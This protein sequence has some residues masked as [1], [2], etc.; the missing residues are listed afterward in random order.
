MFASKSKF[1]A[2]YSIFSILAL[3]FYPLAQVQAK[4]INL[5]ASST[6]IVLIP[7]TV[8][9]SLLSGSGNRCLYVD[10]TGNLLAKGFDCGSASGGDNMGDHSATQNIRLNSY[11]LSGDAGNEGIFV[12]SAG[13]VGVGTNSITAGLRL[14]VSGNL[15]SSGTVSFSGPVYAGGGNRMITVD[16]A[17]VLGAAAIPVD[18]DIYWTGTAT[19]LVPATARTSLGLGAL[20]TLNAVTNTQITDVAW[21]KITG[22]PAACSAG[23]YVRAVGGTLTCST[24]S[25]GGSGT[26]DWVTKWTSSNTLVDSEI[27]SAPSGSGGGVGIGTSNVQPYKLNVAG[28]VNVGGRLTVSLETILNNLAGGGPRMVMVDND[29]LLSASS[30]PAS[31]VPAS[32]PT[33]HTLR[34]NGSNWVSD[35]NIF[36]NGTNVGIGTSVPGAYTL[37]VV[38]TSSFAGNFTTTGT[39]S[40][41]GPVYAGGGNRM[42][43][44]DN[45][46]VLGAAAIPAD[47]D[48]YW[49][50]TATNL[51]PAT[52]RTSLG[53]GALATLNAVTN[54]QITDVAWSKITGFPA[55]CSAGQYVTAVGGTLTCSTPA[56]GADIYWTGTATNLVPATARTSLGLGALATL[57]A[58]TNTQITDVAWSKITGFPAACSAGQ[59]V[60]AVGGT[61]TC[62]TPAGG[63]SGSGTT[64]YVSK[65]TAGSALGNSIIYDNGTYVGI[66]TSVP[67]TYKL[68]VAG[69]SN[70]GGNLTTTGTVSLTGPVYAGGGNRMIT[71]D[72]A[73]VLGAAAIPTD[74]DIY[75]TGT[76]T[77]LVP[78][79]ARTSLGLGALATLGAVSGGTG[80]TITDA[81]VTDADVSS[82][83]AITATKI[84]YGDLFITSAGTSGQIWTSDGTGAGAW[85]APGATTDIY[86]TGTATN[87]VP[88]T[89]RTSLGLGALATLNTVANAQ[90]TDM[91]WSKLTGFPAA[92]SAGQYVSA[93][94]G[95]LTCSTPTDTNTD[96]Y[97]T[98]TAT[99]LVAATART[100]LGL[101]A[102]ATLGAV[103]GGTG[104]TITDSTITDA[105][106]SASAAI[107]SSKLQNGTYFITSAGISGQTWT[108]DG[109]GAGTWATSSGVT[110]GGT[111]G[112]VPYWDAAKNLTDSNIY[113]DHA[114]IGIDMTPTAKLD[115]NGSFRSNSS[116]TFST[117]SGGGTRILTVDNGGVLGATTN[118]IPS[119][120]ISQ[121]MR[122]NGLGGWSATSFLWNS[123]STVGI[124]Y[125]Q[126]ACDTTIKLAVD[127]IIETT[128]IKVDQDLPVGPYCTSSGNIS[129]RSGVMEFTSNGGSGFTFDN[130]VSVTGRVN[131]TLGFAYNGTAG[132]SASY[133]VGTILTAP[134]V[135]G[136]IIVSSTPVTG[137]SRTI[138]VRYNGTSN[139]NLVFTSGVLTSTTCP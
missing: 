51:V 16:N 107:A 69:T 9:N 88:A 73:G 45:A 128:G 136:G 55:A 6:D 7:G 112:L 10:A 3:S 104:G 101:G 115:V 102:L 75:W 121:T 39:V 98:G 132:V 110:G 23:Q 91:A 67:G 117:F 14:L 122:N 26:A 72:N 76:A 33:G 109:L 34:Y 37:R 43:T 84:Q 46:G 118:P 40:L 124:N 49:T 71:V 38:G 103:S 130:P 12:D 52:A 21:S 123:G 94:G 105:D 32:A 96:I 135:W 66:G 65:W 60:T 56:S 11:W 36:N 100:S 125:A 2:Y 54:T 95:T 62:S 29:G 119:G 138:S 24:P 68:N 25:G 48:I 82:S 47:T 108:S 17:G 77:N 20:A 92:C 87:L 18:T 28:D 5:V 35:G 83:A 59:Y 64:N 129:F 93:V 1:F 61:L 78:A 15:S 8:R 90:I 139:C 70:L 41:T 44:V 113:Y 30:I 116:V 126:N 63:V 53:L 127:G 42:I 133:N 86:W 22:F 19:N 114:N 137:L 79:T 106:I 99:N 85:A 50:G 31:G 97:W 27:Y 120:T 13:G 81:S 111:A 74:T 58:V 4:T 131:S 134:S 80:G 57:N 89:A